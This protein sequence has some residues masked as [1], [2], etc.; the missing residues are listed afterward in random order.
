MIFILVVL[1]LK[2]R[3]VWLV[4]FFLVMFK[5]FSILVKMIILVFWILLL[6]V[7]ILFWYLFKI[8]VVVLWLKFL[9]CNRFLGKRFLMLL[10]NWLMKLK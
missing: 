2:V 3:K 7:K 1:V 8:L 5:V 6:K 10:I 9:K 4:S